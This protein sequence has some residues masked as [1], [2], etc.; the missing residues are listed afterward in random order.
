[1]GATTLQWTVVVLFFIYCLSSVGLI[2]RLRTNN[3][4]STM[5]HATVVAFIAAVISVV[6]AL[7]EQQVA[8]I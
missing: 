8:D 2:L 3:S 1:M 4:N 7:L 5:G 6:A